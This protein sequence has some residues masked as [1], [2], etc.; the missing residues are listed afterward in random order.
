MNDESLD[1]FALAWAAPDRGARV[2]ALENQL[3]QCVLECRRS[4][5]SP[6]R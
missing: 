2:A 6:G 5:L 4:K 1:V 3:S